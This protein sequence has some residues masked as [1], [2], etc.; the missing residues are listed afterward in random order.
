M[1][2][3]LKKYFRRLQADA[4][5][6]DVLARLVESK[7]KGFLT[8]EQQS[9]FDDE[10][11]IA[12][13]TDTNPYKE[14]GYRAND[15]PKLDG[16]DGELTEPELRK[17]YAAFARTMAGMKTASALYGA[18]D[19]DAKDFVKRFVDDIKLFPTPKATAECENAIQK[20]LDM[21]DG[22]PLDPANPASALSPATIASVKQRI[23]QTAQIR[24]KE[25]NLKQAFADV[26]ALDDFIIKKIKSKK[27]N[28]DTNV[29]KK[30]K[31]IA[32]GLYNNWQSSFQGDDVTEAV[33]L[34]HNS[35]ATIGQDAAFNEIDI[36][37][38]NLAKFKNGYA[39]ELLN[40]L[41]KNK[42]I[43][44]KFAEQDN[45]EI[46]D[47]LEKAEKKLNYNDPNSSE[48]VKPKTEDVLTPF[49]Q[50][51]KW[52]TDTYNNSMRKYARL[53]GDPLLF[54]AFSKEIFKAIDKEKVKPTDGIEGLLGKADAIKKRLPNKIVEEH[55]D[56][57]VETMNKIKA[58]KQ[59]A[60]AG[61]WNNAAQMKCVITEI[62]LKATGPNAKD[63][64]MEKAKTAMEIMTAMKYGMMTSKVM[65][66]LKQTD[67]TVFSDGK[68]SWNK[69]EGVQFVTKAFD[70]SVKAAFLGV[71]YAVTF[72]RNKIMMRNMKFTDKDNQK[73]ALA[74]R[75]QKE[76][77]RINNGTGKNALQTELNA[78]ITERDG[79]RQTI[80][81]LGSNIENDKRRKEQIDTELAPWIQRKEQ[82]STIMEEQAKIKKE[83]QE[84][85]D[86]Y[87]S[88]KDKVEKLNDIL[89]D[90]DIDNKITKI[91]NQ[92]DANFEKIK[93]INDILKDPVLKDE[94]GNPITDRRAQG[95]YK[96]K[97]YDILG[98]L[99]NENRQLHS[100]IAE[101][102]AKRNDSQRHDQ[103]R[104]EKNSLRQDIIKYN[105]AQVAYN[106]ADAQYNTAKADLDNANNEYDQIL[107]R[108]N[109]EYDTI[110]N[111]IEQFTDATKSIEEINKTIEEK[112]TA[113]DNW[114]EKHKNKVI[115]L[116]DFWNFLQTGKT[117]T[118]RL[119][120][121]K[122]QEN[123][124]EHKQEWLKDY[125][126]QH[127]LR[128]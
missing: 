82:A 120:T 84:I 49:Q 45:D 7:K 72:A 68:L 109:D 106:N 124:D 48:Y 62:I 20:L 23:V 3:F 126:S 56:W 2:D 61:A 66:A 67:F 47:K 30:I 58:E 5:D 35:L 97:L 99:H 8:P 71:G 74:A 121:D 73:G 102:N 50:I 37:D 65:D 93:N 112:Q 110:S 21:L 54:S 104:H 94:Q 39:E 64:D 118:F 115:E 111:K 125:I 88:S 53:R 98:D 11:F 78:K 29:Q 69:N 79:H 80:Q 100:H 46:I 113:L 42:D 34:I 108:N 87:Q 92:I 77:A 90:R 91:Q 12:D 16:S 128:Y 19:S 89:S 40:T 14:L 57:F 10:I 86:E 75:I 18:K 60:V 26:P 13:D 103:A 123:F 105:Q 52:A 51:E 32:N 38:D 43:R 114:D 119:L 15:L 70:Q 1:G 127:G 76:N 55:F 107:H 44:N 96:R 41:Y 6:Y 17:L 81:N 24:D 95:S 116:E 83:Q 25:G 28:S 33:S 122:A 36:S 63:G 27:Y 9:W 59:N 85:I 101:E 4:M 22:N 117:K 31:G